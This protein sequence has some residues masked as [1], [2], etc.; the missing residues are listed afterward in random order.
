MTDLME[1]AALHTLRKAE[2]GD[3]SEL[4]EKLRSDE[5]LAKC[6]REFLAS[7]LE[8]NF[9][10]KRGPKEQL[11]YLD[12][13]VYEAY[14]WLIYRNIKK[15]AVECELADKIS[16]TERSVRNRVDRAKRLGGA[17]AASARFRASDLNEWAPVPYRERPP[18]LLARNPREINTS[19]IENFKRI[20]LKKSL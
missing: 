17:L 8:G 13:E 19:V 2:E 4:L 15:H 1:L 16:E 20:T 14:C 9:K 7:Y 6:E 10:Q 5:P 18:P 3:L 12:I 11:Q